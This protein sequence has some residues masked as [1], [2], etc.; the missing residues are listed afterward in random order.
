M[1]YTFLT[2]E[3]WGEVA[4]REMKHLMMSHIYQ[5]VDTIYFTAGVNNL[6][7]IKAIEKIGGKLLTAEM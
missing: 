7:S 6:R 1:G 4:N 2:R 3:Y 5:W